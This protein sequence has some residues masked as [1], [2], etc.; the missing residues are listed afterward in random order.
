MRWLGVLFF[1]FGIGEEGRRGEGDGDGERWD[2]AWSGHG[3]EGLDACAKVLGG[4][5]EGWVAGFC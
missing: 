3:R 4:S 2:E 1:F 5:L